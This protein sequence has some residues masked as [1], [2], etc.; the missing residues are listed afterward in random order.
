MAVR[1]RQ[2]RN[3]IRPLND[4]PV[5]VD[6]PSSTSE[7]TLLG[8]PLLINDTD[9]DNDPLV[10]MLETSPSVGTLSFFSD[11][12]EYMPPPDFHG[13]TSF[14][15]RAFDG[16]ALSNLA[17]VTIN[18]GP[19]NDRP[20]ARNDAFA[21]DEDIAGSLAVLANDTDPDGDPLTVTE[22]GTPLHGTVRMNQ[23]RTVT[24]TP[25]LNFHGIDAFTY[26]VTDSHGE[27]AMATVE[28]TI[29]PLN[30]APVAVDDAATIAE[31]TIAEM[32]LLD[33]DTDADNDLL[34]VMIVTQPAVGDLLTFTNGV[35]YTP[36]ANFNGVV[37]FTYRATDGIVQSNLATVTI[38]VTGINDLPIAFADALAINEDSPGIVAILANDTDPDGDP[39]T[40]TELGTPLH[41]TVRMNQDRTVTYTP[42][43]NY[44]GSDAFTYGISDGH[45]AFAI[46]RVEMTIAPL[47]DAPVAVDDAMTS[48]EDTLAFVHVLTNDTDADNDL[49]TFDIVTGVAV[50]GLLKFADHVS[51]FRRRTSTAR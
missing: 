48:S 36:P 4:V 14:T 45:G 25:A 28:V 20:L 16:L 8:I 21:I 1:D 34:S 17:T 3:D 27:F 44:H 29:R 15:Y 23:D 33:N 38:T 11:R 10:Y 5:A 7:D 39:L 19:I 51:T 30:D 31:D 13:T 22:L 2:S 12:V 49:L 26:R 37:T 24:Y 41:G 46:G 42:A 18:V 32:H 43:L 40:V 47:N 6:D 35:N 50:G 9:A